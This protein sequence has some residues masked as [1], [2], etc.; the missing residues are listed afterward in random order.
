MHNSLDSLNSESNQSL[1]QRLANNPALRA[2]LHALVD[3]IDAAAGDCVTAAQAEARVVEEI[4]KMGAEA[5][6]AWSQRAEDH[7]QSQMSGQQAERDGKKN[8][9]G[10]RSSEKST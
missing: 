7:A 6:T 2:R 4:R 10:I 3:V 8:S 5:L 1:D 9:T